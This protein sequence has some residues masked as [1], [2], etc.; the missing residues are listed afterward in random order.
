MH[1]YDDVRS[2]I[3]FG[4]SVLLFR[5]VCKCRCACCTG[6]ADIAFDVLSE[7]IWF[8]MIAGVLEFVHVLGLEWLIPA[9]V[10]QLISCLFVELALLLSFPL[11]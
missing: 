7:W 2:V 1:S 10:W 3:D 5:G 4:V 6:L 8:C 9:S 11:V